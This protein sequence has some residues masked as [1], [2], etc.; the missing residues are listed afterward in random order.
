MASDIGG[1]LGLLVGFAFG[2]PYFFITW[3]GI[4]SFAHAL[5]I[6]LTPLAP[7]MV[8]DKRLPTIQALAIEGRE[9]VSQGNLIMASRK[10]E[11]A[12]TKFMEFKAF[13]GNIES[14]GQ[15][16]ALWINQTKTEDVFKD[17]VPALTSKETVSGEMIGKLLLAS[18]YLSSSFFTHADHAF[19]FP[20]AKRESLPRE[21]FPLLSQ[22]RREGPL[23][24]NPLFAS[25][26][27]PIIYT[28]N[29]GKRY[30]VK[31]LGWGSFTDL[32][33]LKLFQQFGFS[34]TDTRHLSKDPGLV[35]TPWIEGTV[36]LVQ[37]MEDQLVNPLF[38]KED[39]IRDKLLPT[40]IRDVLESSKLASMIVEYTDFNLRNVLLFVDAN[41]NLL[42][43]PPVFFDFERTFFFQTIQ[44]GGRGVDGKKYRDGFS[45]SHF[46]SKRDTN[47]MTNGEPLFHRNAELGHMR[48]LFT[49]LKTVSEDDIRG[50]VDDA[51]AEY[52]PVDPMKHLGVN[53]DEL[54][55]KLNNAIK[56]ALELENSIGASSKM[57]LHKADNQTGQAT[58]WIGVG[59]AWIR[60]QMAWAL[61]VGRADK[62]TKNEFV[63][64]F[65]QDHAAESEDWINF[66]VSV[67]L[68]LWAFALMGFPVPTLDALISPNLLA[69][70]LWATVIVPALW[71]ALFLLLHVLRK[72][73]L[74]D[75]FGITP[76]PSKAARLLHFYAVPITLAM[77]AGM[78]LGTLG[79]PIWVAA[80]AVVGIIGIPHRWI[81]NRHNEINQGT[82]RNQSGSVWSFLNRINHNARVREGLAAIGVT[83]VMGTFYYVLGTYYSGLFGHLS[84]LTT[85][86][87]IMGTGVINGVTTWW[88]V[89]RWQNASGLNPVSF[90][91]VF[92]TQLIF[93]G[94]LF[95]FVGN[96]AIRL[97]PGIAGIAPH[98]VQALVGQFLV[99][100]FVFDPLSYVV[101]RRFVFG[102][103]NGDLFK[104]L[105]K[106]MLPY[107]VLNAMIWTPI[108]ALGLSFP[109]NAATNIVA[110]VGGI[111]AG[112]IGLLF[113]LRERLPGLNLDGNNIDKIRFP[114]FRSFARLLSWFFDQPWIP[115]YLLSL[116]ALGY[117]ALAGL[118]VYSIFPFSIAW[119][120][121]TAVTSLVLLVSFN[122]TRA[123]N[124][125]M[126]G[127]LKKEPP[128]NQSPGDNI[129]YRLTKSAQPFVDFLASGDDTTGNIPDVFVVSGSNDLKAYTEFAKVWNNMGSNIP[130]IVA[131]G[132][133]SGTIVLI[134]K[135]LSFYASRLTSE[136]RRLLEQAISIDSSITEREILLKVVFPLENI[137]EEQITNWFLE[138]SRSSRTTGENM[139]N[140]SEIIKR[141]LGQ[142]ENPSVALVN[143]PILLLRQSLYAKKIWNNDL[144]NTWAI[145][146]FP[147]YRP[148]LS[149]ME[150]NE[151][152]ETLARLLGSPDPDK[153]DFTS[154]GELK[155]VRD[156]S[157]E[158]PSSIEI[159]FDFLENIISRTLPLYKEFVDS[160][161]VQYD[162]IVKLLIVN[163]S[164]PIIQPGEVN[165]L[166]RV[167]VLGFRPLL[168]GGVVTTVL[169]LWG[170]S[171]FA[172]P[173]GVISTL[174]TLGWEQGWLRGPTL[175]TLQT[176]GLIMAL[177]FSPLGEPAT[178][179]GVQGTPPVTLSPTSNNQQTP[180]YQINAN[181]VIH[182]TDL[183]LADFM[184]MKAR[185]IVSQAAH[186]TALNP[187]NISPWLQE[188]KGINV[189]FLDK[190][191]VSDPA[192]RAALSTF[193]KNR[194]NVVIFTN[195]EGL[196]EA[197]VDIRYRPMSFSA[198]TVQTDKGS[199]PSGIV[200]VS[201]HNLSTDLKPLGQT[202]PLQFFQTTSLNLN[203]NKDID[204][205]LANLTT[206]SWFLSD[207]FEILAPAGMMDWSKILRTLAEI[208]RHA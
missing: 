132:R 57:I 116:T 133:G 107:V 118:V 128:H 156:A 85:L 49:M 91:P 6:V 108:A 135:C 146:R 203:A 78:G 138:E 88:L 100:P 69:V 47:R 96:E 67:A 149:E 200:E 145:R 194:P 31:Y 191:S 136:Q 155:G 204:A 134:R 70:F 21:D 166:S 60:A 176:V 72:Q 129:R 181:L 14:L 180:S 89:N 98:W 196:K 81:R 79:T 197:G 59:V 45:I 73:S 22:L 15:E 83:L 65:V 84:R 80:I 51:M 111:L 124:Y 161:V 186:A 184:D 76:E 205:D 123:L 43:K 56:S 185:E 95:G 61:G 178:A 140:V 41:G 77:G 187:P 38:F 208:A 126:N 171:T 62:T 169:A 34:T 179:K 26:S 32:L 75:R 144:N 115:N 18:L 164:R 39:S 3:F 86:S 109:N 177:V 23:E 2:L 20:S 24:P 28:S 182:P 189:L 159:D 46:K 141:V 193:L 48:S 50:I 1:V 7:A 68:G 35:M 40:A 162:P 165:E 66:V 19:S 90:W 157:N 142:K 122:S 71:P 11:E 121:T 74:R 137:T 30:V 54:I 172:V 202:V 183:G 13:S 4:Y 16:L 87:I 143:T 10:F 119:F 139:Q 114:P 195:D 63:K 12:V 5:Q 127:Q 192:R 9:F 168:L 37:F 153:W 52:Y 151:L 55:S 175:R 53:R 113:V 104:G 8:D 36:T 64:K 120:F 44:I 154:K 174:V 198:I 173:V 148:V 206:R 42:P 103:T 201:I 199:V 97:I 188:G 82:A 160:Q 92:L 112:A 110:S 125:I 99:A 158:N 58:G 94:P 163:N 33:T 147:T 93:F 150:D 130:V 167:I 207:T 29:A 170:L 190:R 101:M 102:E 25:A 131:G 106:N 17:N 27:N 117:G 105:K 152:L